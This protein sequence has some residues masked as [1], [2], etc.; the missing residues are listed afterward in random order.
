MVESR[1]AGIRG[2]VDQDEPVA[3][4]IA[5]RVPETGTS[6]DP[7]RPDL[8]ADNELASADGNRPLPQ[9]AVAVLG[10]STVSRIGDAVSL[11]MSADLPD[12]R[13]RGCASYEG[14]NFTLWAGEPIKSRR[15]WHVYYSA[16]A[17]LRPTC[18]AAETRDEGGA[19]SGDQTELPAF[20]QRLRP[21]ARAEFVEHPAAVRLDRV[22]AHK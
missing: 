10:D 2:R 3:G 18:D 15:I 12:V 4:A 17:N 8:V 11:R 5:Y 6:V 9:F 19:A 13:A 1:L 7:S 21:P 22:F 16:G 14:I 20:L